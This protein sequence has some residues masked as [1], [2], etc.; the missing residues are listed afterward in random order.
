M[1]KRAAERFRAHGHA[2]IADM[3]AAS[4]E[5]FAATWAGHDV[6]VAAGPGGRPVGFAAATP[7]DGFL[8]LAELSVDPD[9]GRIGIGRALVEAVAA[10]AGRRG[11]PG[12]T[13]TTF[14]DIPFNAPFYARLGF[15]EMPLPEVPVAS[16]ER[17]LAEL[18]PGTAVET[19]VLM[20]RRL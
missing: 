17:F 18:P 7:L 15:L 9:H 1:E 12:V 19:R 5:A 6:L 14:R 16:R 20:L 4:P 10:L 13:L 2:T 3:P 11:L 8:H